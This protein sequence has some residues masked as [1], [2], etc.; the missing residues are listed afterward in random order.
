MPILPSS[1]SNLNNKVNSARKGFNSTLDKAGEKSGVFKSSS[2]N[3]QKKP[4]INNLAS[5][6]STSTLRSINSHGPPPP[7]PPRR[8]ISQDNGPPPPVSR[9]PTLAPAPPSYASNPPLLSRAPSSNTASYYGP[10][11]PPSSAPPRRTYAQPSLHDSQK[12][13]FPPFSK[14]TESDKL[15]FFALLDE[16]FESKSTSTHPPSSHPPPPPIARHSRPVK[17]ASTF[18]ASYLNSATAATLFT[19]FS[20]HRQW[21]A[22]SD[23]W[24]TDSDPIPPLI[25]GATDVKRISSWSQTGIKRTQL[26][27]ILFADL[28][29]AWSSVTFDTSRP[30]PPSR[31]QAAYRPTPSPPPTPQL[32]ACAES[33]GPYIVHFAETAE[34][35]GRHVARG[36]CWD[37]ANEALKAIPQLA[38]HLPPPMRSVSRTHGWLLYHGRATEADGHWIASDVGEVRPGDFIEWNLVACDT[39]NPIL[40]CTLGDPVRISSPFLRDFII[41]IF[42]RNVD[43]N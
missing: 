24:Y 4:S 1:L 20:N 16:F 43:R 3:P 38:P 29:Q 14:F 40:K 36:E 34:R 27:Y 7:P 15:A 9:K 11:S 23:Q 2:S 31:A 25:K 13:P 22:H 18:T 19:Y 33:Y 41:F 21:S 30:F 39:V 42:F 5:S 8:V 6:S 17:S 32:V 35:S 37:L 10:P 12:I 26:N 28:S